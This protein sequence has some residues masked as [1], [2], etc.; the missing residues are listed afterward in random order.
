M[1]EIILDCPACKKPVQ[2]DDAWAGQEIACPI[3][4]ATMLVPQAAAPG[5]PAQSSKSSMGKQLVQVPTGTKLSLGSAQVA[6]AADGRG[7]TQ[8]SFQPQKVKQKIPI[9]RYAIIGVVIVALAASAWIAWPYLRPYVPFLKKAEEASAPAPG[10]AAKLAAGATATETAPPPPPK[11]VPMTAP[12]YTLDVAQATI[13]EGKVNGSVA[14]T[15]FVPD[16][17]RLDQFVGGYV[18]TLRQGPG[19]TPD[20]G[21]RVY[22][23]LKPTDSPT[24]HTWT[25]SQEM[26]GTGVS[27]LVKV[28]KPN[29]KFAAK[30]KSF[31]TGFALKLEFGQLTAS[32]TIPGKIFAALPDPEQTVIAGVFNATT[33]LAGGQETTAPQPLIQNPKAGTQSPEFQKRYGTGR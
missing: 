23:Q 3:C 12:A 17:V 20:R 19:Q 33:S 31:T 11:E 22:L 32:N 10:A 27:Q 30:E 13:S 26:K 18:L 16:M 1:A 29:P 25:V 7:M 28:W 15:N 5:A 21:L 4:N 2:A 6:R 14:G 8:T 9:L 24:G